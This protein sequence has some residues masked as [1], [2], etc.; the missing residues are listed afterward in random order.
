M[1]N[2]NGIKKCFRMILFLE[3]ILR[4]T[5]WGYEEQG[6]DLALEI[7]R[8]LILIFQDYQIITFP[9]IINLS[10]GLNL[11]ETWPLILREELDWRNFRRRRWGIYLDGRGMKWCNVA[12]NSIMK[13]FINC[14]IYQVYLDNKC[15][16][17]GIGRANSWHG[18]KRYIRIY[19]ISVGNAKGNRKSG[20]NRRRY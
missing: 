9:Q 15:E 16:K 10:V 17:H 19:M 7:L 6:S 1:K 2:R 20:K 18:D 8:I 11:C 4:R 5:E 13:S 14:A 12:G 3:C